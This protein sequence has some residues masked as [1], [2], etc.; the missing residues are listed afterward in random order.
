MP[1][2]DI[3]CSGVFCLLLPFPTASQWKATLGTWLH[4]NKGGGSQ[5][6]LPQLAHQ[7]LCPWT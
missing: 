7:T 1:I 6:L 3:C 4:T 5:R 2:R